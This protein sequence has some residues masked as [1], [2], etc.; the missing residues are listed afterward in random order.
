MAVKK[1]SK[2]NVVIHNKTDK[3]DNVV[4]RENDVVEKC[5]EIEKQL[6]NFMRGYFSYLKSAVMT[7]T[8]LAYLADLKFFC[9]YLINET[10]ITSAEK[11]KDIKEAEFATITARDVNYYINDF[12]RHYRV[13]KE[14]EIYIYENGN[15]SLSRKK[16]SLSVLFKYLYRDEVMKTNI[17]DGFDPIRLP[18]PGEREIKRLDIDEVKIMIDAALEGEGLTKKEK[19]Y[20]ARTRYRDTAILVLFVTYGLRLYELQQLNI[21]SFDFHKGEFKIYRKRGKEATMP[22][23]NSTLKV[24]KDYIELERPDSSLLA[25]EYQDALFLSLQKKRITERAIRDLVK[26]YTSIGMKRS[27]DAGYS[28]HKLRAT[29]ATALIEEGHSIFDVQQLL[30]HDNVTTTQLYAAHKRNTKREIVDNFEWLDEYE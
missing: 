25:E 9:E 11:P 10:D 26:K 7:N 3:P 22:L 14:D 21:S 12:C 28:P 19:A 17:T 23:N 6:P 27:R 29:A 1:A 16:S 18:K 30:D 5:I 20:W 13:E 2:K 4:K 15:R 8:R 24:I